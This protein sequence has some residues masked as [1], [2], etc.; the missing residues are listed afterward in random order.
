MPSRV[1]L[2]GL[3]Y[4]VAR[5][6][7]YAGGFTTEHYGQPHEGVHAL[8]I[9]IN[10]AP[11]FGRARVRR[12]E[13]MKRVVRDMTTLIDALSAFDVS[14]WPRP[15]VRREPNSR[16]NLQKNGPRKVAQ[17]QGGNTQDG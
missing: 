8:Q 3:G 16:G 2:A 13:G 6:I 10:R 1:V 9:E 14:G 4:R 7:P 5:N 17:V 12:T 15:G 11:V